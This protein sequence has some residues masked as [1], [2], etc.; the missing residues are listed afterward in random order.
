MSEESQLK[1]R[2]VQKAVQS[3]KKNK[4]FDQISLLAIA[5][6]LNV[7]FSEVTKYYGSIEDIFLHQQ[8]RNWKDTYKRLNKTIKSAKTVGDFKEVFDTFIQ[9]FVENLGSDSALN[10]E[11]CSFLPKCLEFREKN[12]KELSK[13]LKQ[14]IRRGWPGKAP[15]VLDR[16]TAL[17]VL[18]FYGFIDHVVH[19]PRGERSKILKDFRNMLNLHLQDRLFF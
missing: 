11:V 13:R 17:C 15:N 12:K 6:E 10:W 8:K 19:I 4:K 5:K 3:V 18:S 14:V 7:D 1:D 9:D 16:Q 2:I